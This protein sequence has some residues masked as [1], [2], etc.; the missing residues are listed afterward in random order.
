[1]LPSHT[2]L[3]ALPPP[4]VCIKYLFFLRALTTCLQ[5]LPV[6]G[7][8]EDAWRNSTDH[9]HNLQTVQLLIKK[10]RQVCL[11]GEPT[12]GGREGEPEDG[13]V[14]RPQGLA[15]AACCCGLS[16]LWVCAPNRTDPPEGDP[17]A[18]ASH[19][20]I[21][22]RGARTSSLT[23]ASTPRPSAETGHD[24]KQLWGLLIEETGEAALAAGGGH[25]AQQYYFDAAERLLRRDERAGAVHDV[26]GEGQGEEGAH[27]CACP[28]ARGASDSD[29]K[30]VLLGWHPCATSDCCLVYG[31]SMAHIGD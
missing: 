26:R 16:E 5:F 25:R 9:G 7:W 14:L 22:L 6:V 20:R 21:S 1:M 31:G 24:L 12:C 11:L 2:G 3:L 13:Q 17:G 18:P 15:Q 19:R 30:L 29:L 8:R 23:A 4:L 27:P 10:I 28:C